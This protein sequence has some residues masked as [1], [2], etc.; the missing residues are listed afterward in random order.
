MGQIPFLF[1]YI[2]P[3]FIQELI[4]DDELVLKMFGLRQKITIRRA[5]YNLRQPVLQ[6]TIFLPEEIDGSQPGHVLMM[7]LLQYVHQRV[8]L[9]SL[10]MFFMIFIPDT[11]S[12]P[13]SMSDFP[14]SFPGLLPMRTGW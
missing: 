11:P 13:V 7:I 9:R 4:F 1:L 2:V 5:I 6:K 10:L 12:L 3:E 8:H 14:S